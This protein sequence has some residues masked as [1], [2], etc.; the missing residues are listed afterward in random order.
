MSCILLASFQVLPLCEVWVRLFV[1]IIINLLK[2]THEPRGRPSGWNQA[3]FYGLMAL[4][5]S[6]Y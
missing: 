6:P 2:N 3:N 5:V 4:L 1:L